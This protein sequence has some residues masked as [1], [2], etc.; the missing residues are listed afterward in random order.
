LAD[1]ILPACTNF[2]RNDIG[3]WANT[4]GYT[5]HGSSACNHRV[6]V[7]QQKCIEPLGDSKSD[8]EIVCLVAEK[9]GLLE[10]YT[11]GKSHEEALGIKML[12]GAR[13]A[14]EDGAQVEH[15]VVIIHPGND[16]RGP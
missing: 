14:I 2:E 7:Y 15:N 12:Q 16:G 3:E 8:Y 6:I 9:L 10:K 13:L 11:G 4:G 5:H 1:I